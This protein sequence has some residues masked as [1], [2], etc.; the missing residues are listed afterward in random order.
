MVEELSRKPRTVCQDPGAEIGSAQA[1]RKGLIFTVQS[2]SPGLWEDVRKRSHTKAH[3]EVTM[4]SQ[5]N[6]TEAKTG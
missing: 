6:G 3:V 5:I 4:K 1:L 2:F